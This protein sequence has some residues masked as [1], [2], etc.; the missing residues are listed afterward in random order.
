MWDGPATVLENTL[1]KAYIPVGR[2][3][4]GRIPG[5]MIRGPAF[6]LYVQEEARKYERE[7]PNE[8]YQEWHRLY[9][10]PAP[11][12][13]KPWQFKHLTVK[14]IW[15]PLAKSS[16]KILEL[17]RALKAQDGD[18]QKNWLLNKFP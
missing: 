16:G 1:A 17:V 7:F 12:R 13:G 9:Q 10:I 11:L 8:L 14:H 5:L 4:W 3:L 18:R 2:F 6:K 15:F